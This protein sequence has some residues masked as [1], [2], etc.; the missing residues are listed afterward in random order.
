MFKRILGLF[1]VLLIA[2]VPPVLYGNAILYPAM[3]YPG[4]K[5]TVEGIQAQK[6]G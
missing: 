6:K 3:A 4:G 2:M 5:A 1:V